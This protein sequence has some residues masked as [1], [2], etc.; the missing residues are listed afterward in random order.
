MCDNKCGE[1]GFKFYQIS[2]IVTEEGGAH[3]IILCKTC[4]NV[5]WLERGE[6]QATAST[7][8]ELVV[9]KAFRGKTVGSTWHGATRAQNVGMF[10]HQ[11]KAGARSVLA[12]G[13]WQHET[14]HK[15]ELE[16][17]QAQQ[18]PAFCRCAGSV[19]R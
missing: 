7:W 16:A 12:D 18:R 9:Q 13:R 15:E 8:R 14:P 17:C 2:A 6:Q 4:Y 5:R 1:K 10:H 19:R 11:K 3:T